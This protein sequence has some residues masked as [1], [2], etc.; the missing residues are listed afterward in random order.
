MADTS[1]INRV[2]GTN[3][4]LPHEYLQKKILQEKLLSH[5]E[6]FGYQTIETPILEHSEL[7]LRKSGEDIVSRMYDFEYQNRRLCLRPE[8]TAA[9]IRAYI[10]N[11]Q[12]SALP[13]RLSYAG[14]VFRYEKPQF[15]RYRQFTQVGLELI[16]TKSNKVSELPYEAEVLGDAETISIA[17]SMMDKLNVKAYNLVL[18]N[19]EILVSFLRQIGLQGQMQNFL[20]FNMEKLRK[21]GLDQLIEGIRDLNPDFRF[22]EDFVETPSSGS[23]NPTSLTDVLRQ[24]SDDDARSAVLEF[25]STLNIDIQSNRDNLDII[26]GLLSKIKN[27]DQNPRISQAIS[28]M[29]QLAEIKGSSQAVLKEAHSLLTM[30]KVDTSPL[31]RL[32]MLVEHLTHAG[33]DLDKVTIDLGLNRGL[34]Y[35][36]SLVF[37][38][39]HDGLS[40]E[41]QLCGGG[42][43]D[44]LVELLGGRQKLDTTGFSF[45]L[46]RLQMA[47]ESE[48]VHASK[49]QI[50][51]V[52]II[53]V[54]A[55]DIQYTYQVAST[56]RDSHIRVENAI[57][58]RNMRNHLQY[59]D[60]KNIP[61]VIIIGSAERTQNKIILRDMR[62]GEEYAM[63]VDEAISKIENIKEVV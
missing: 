19:V 1:S 60:K 62:K 48:R 29:R 16:G 14:P 11:L 36:T 52:L 35:Y 54:A 28:F 58:D 26:D 8:L 42:R 7:Y 4:I 30:Y 21:E 41:R 37:E 38:I 10:D 32:E 5:Y 12:D 50:S 13:V 2:K 46:E 47:L 33:V 43:Y 53:P 55:D 18:G 6:L 9:I 51:D 22:V 40:E 31:M 44:D 49:V 25:L 3:D 61:F 63:K 17:T 24:M 39:H 34:Q 59:A 20:M 27:Q 45:G 57:R 15:A 23:D 56:L